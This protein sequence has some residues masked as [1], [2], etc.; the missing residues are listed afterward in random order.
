MTM[1]LK[2]VLGVIGLIAVGMVM[3]A[4]YFV[5]Q[6]EGYFKAN[7]AWKVQAVQ[8]V[9]ADT[10]NIMTIGS[11]LQAQIASSSKK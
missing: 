8:E 4:A 7:D 5:L 11:Y 3:A 1:K 6:V 10:Q 9:N 2:I